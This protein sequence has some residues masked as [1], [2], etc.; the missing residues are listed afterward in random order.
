MWHIKCDMWHVTHGWGWICSQSFSSP[1]LTVGKNSVLKIL[2]KRMSGSMNHWVTQVIVEQPR[3]HRVCWL[4][5]MSRFKYKTI[6]PTI[7]RQLIKNDLLNLSEFTS[8]IL[9]LLV[10]QWYFL[11]NPYSTPVPVI[12]HVK[13]CLAPG[14]LYRLPTTHSGHRVTL[15]QI[16]S[17]ITLGPVDT[18]PPRTSPTNL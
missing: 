16:W 14:N 11:Q 18:D 10:T 17:W 1:P 13:L 8:D 9:C 3:L 15:P 7:W 2:N 6:Y 12:R 5:E 4:E